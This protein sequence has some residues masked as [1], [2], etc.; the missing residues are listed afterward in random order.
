[1][2]LWTWF[3]FWARAKTST[4]R[5]ADGR[6]AAAQRHDP[7]LGPRPPNGGKA[8]LSPIGMRRLPCLCGVD[9]FGEVD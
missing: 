7:Q 3:D 2:T 8:G 6:A 1:V 5:V 9:R 4:W